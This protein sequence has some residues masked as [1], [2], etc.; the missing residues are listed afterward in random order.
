MDA[1]NNVE[2][3]IRRR[4]NQRAAAARSLCSR[5]NLCQAP[6]FF[7]NDHEVEGLERFLRAEELGAEAKMSYVLRVL[8]GEAVREKMRVAEL[9]K[10]KKITDETANP[11]DTM[12]DEFVFK[13]KKD[14]AVA[15]QVSG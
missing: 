6:R 12:F 4:G 3:K 15:R 9:V 13:A 7:I 8:H 14:I 5:K 11:L 10:E 2:S 1:F